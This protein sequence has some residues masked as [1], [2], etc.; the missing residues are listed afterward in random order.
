MNP[1]GTTHLVVY[2]SDVLMMA[3]ACAGC[4][5]AILMGFHT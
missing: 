3:G 4:L 1:W 2:V 5:S